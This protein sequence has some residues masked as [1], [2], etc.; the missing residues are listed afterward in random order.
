VPRVIPGLTVD[1]WSIARPLL[2]IVLLPMVVGML[3]LRASPAI[4]TRSLPPVKA[5]TSVATIIMLAM[6]A[7]IYGKGFAEAV[8]TRAIGAQVLFFLI[9]TSTA[10]ASGKGLPPDRR[11]VLTLGICTRNVGAALAPLLATP[12]TDQRI[13]VMV[14]MGV[15]LQLIF[16]LSATKWLTGKE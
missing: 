15:P 14:V 4:A 12:G 1:A 10:Y 9:V 7:V 5:V 3:T 2:L 13:V 6:C 11:S 16:A 8:G